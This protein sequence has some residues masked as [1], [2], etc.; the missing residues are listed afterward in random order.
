[1]KE[2]YQCVVSVTAIFSVR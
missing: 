2:S 1:M